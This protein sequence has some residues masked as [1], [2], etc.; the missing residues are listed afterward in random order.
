MKVTTERL[1]IHSLFTDHDFFRLAAQF[2]KPEFFEEQETRTIFTLVEDYVGKYSERPSITET[3]GMVAELAV[4]PETADLIE[5]ILRFEPDDTIS[6]E[7]ITNTAEEYCKRRAM[8]IALMESLDIIEGKS[9]LPLHAVSDMMDRAVN[10]KFDPDIGLNFYDDIERKI[11]GYNESVSKIP[12]KLAMLNKITNG[13]VER[14]TVNVM[15]A[16]SNF[17]K[18]IYLADEAVFQSK[19]GLNT[20]YVTFEMSDDRISRRMDANANDL[21]LDE[22]RKYTEEQLRD[23]FNLLRNKK[24]GYLILKEFGP[25]EVTAAKL[26]LYLKEVEMAMGEPVDVLVVD[27][28]NLMTSTRSGREN[29][30][31]LNGK[32]VSEDLVSLAKK[33]NIAIFTAVQFG[34]QGQKNTSPEVTD[35]A[36]SQAIT[37][38]VDFLI[39]GFDTEELAKA[40]RAIFKQLKNRFGSKDEYKTFLVG[41]ERGKM[42]F[43]DVSESESHGLADNAGS[44]IKDVNRTPKFAKD[45]INSTNDEIFQNFDFG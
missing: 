21:T 38:T 22:I 1:L 37:N 8:K 4:N 39:A 16:P 29:S 5:E 17:G 15:A 3:M 20:V 11:E 27:Y 43:F 19:Q 9:K 18:S 23:T 33:L 41:L 6:T 42:K 28:L 44:E 31:F 13:G 2:L 30:L 26:R 12:F 24:H 35:I 7:W 34:R 14:K 10:F 25:G 36:E 32:Y 45:A 40:N